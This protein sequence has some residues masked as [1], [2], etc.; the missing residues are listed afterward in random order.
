MKQTRSVP[1]ISIILVMIIA[2]IRLPSVASGDVKPIT[3]AEEKLENISE[4]EKAVLEELFFISQR[5]DEMEL[6]EKQIAKDI[7]RI[8]I[9]IEEIE[10]TIEE[11]QEKID[12]QVAIMEQFMVLYQR[13]GPASF[14]EYLL[15]AGNL[16]E[17]LKSINA[18]KDI[19]KNVNNLLTSIETDKQILEQ[20]KEQLDERV[21]QLEKKKDK[22]QAALQKQ[23]ELKQEQ[24][25]YLASLEVNKAFFEDQLGNLEQLWEANKI[26]FAEIVGELTRI[27]GEGYFSMEDLNVTFS[28]TGI[29]GFIYDDTFNQ[30]LNEHSGLTETIFN[31]EPGWITVEVPENHLVLGGTFTLVDDSTIEFIPENGSFYDMTLEQSSL[32]ELFL[33]S[34][35]TIDFKAIAAGMVI[36]D[37]TV[38]TVESQEGLLAFEIKPQF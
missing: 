3:E 13:R 36:I 6:E 5:I 27:A 20:E 24:E 16:T 38:K 21:R 2:F 37:F 23:R 22:L 29:K 14:L 32:D 12:S 25:E 35:L 19:A 8:Q 34:A 17:F 26:L 10:C 11:K 33:E 15:K 4:E 7:D 30:V 18:I 9:D 31:F 1:L 28:F